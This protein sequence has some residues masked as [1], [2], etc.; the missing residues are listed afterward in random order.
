MIVAARAA[1]TRDGVTEHAQVARGRARGTST[2]TR[3]VR[4]RL[5]RRWPSG[6]PIAIEARREARARSAMTTIR[7]D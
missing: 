4:R 3:T 1:R 2:C 7:E 5:R 6:E